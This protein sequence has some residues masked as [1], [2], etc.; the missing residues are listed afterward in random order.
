MELKAFLQ[1]FGLHARLLWGIVGACMVIGITFFVTQPE[2]YSAALTLNIA[3]TSGEST[4]QENYAGFYR[5]QADERFSDTI[6]K[7]LE[8]PRVVEKIITGTGAQEILSE[9]ELRSAFSAQRLSSQVVEVRYAANTA[10]DAR[11]RAAQILSVLNTMTEE[12]NVNAQS[13]QWFVI[14]GEDPVVRPHALGFLYLTL[15]SLSIGLFLGLVSVLFWH[16][17]NEDDKSGSA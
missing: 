4:A 11:A 8:S 9:R 12:L 15:L 2:R 10:A 3:R 14:L 16:Y 17:Y 7:W 6:V 1:I 5:L 13:E